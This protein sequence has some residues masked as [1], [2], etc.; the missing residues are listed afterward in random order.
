MSTQPVPSVPGV[1]RASWPRRAPRRLEAYSALCA[2]SFVCYIA[3]R[4]T[5]GTAGILFSAIGAGACGWA[6]LLTRALFDPA[7]R[8]VW[9]PRI[10]GTVVAVAG[11]ITVLAPAE[12]G[13]S[14]F[15]ANVYRLSGSAAMLL[16]FIEP[17]QARRGH[18]GVGEKRFRLTFLTVNAAQLVAVLGSGVASQV[19]ADV[20]RTDMIR[21]A[22]CIVG[23][24]GG[25]VA[26]WYRLRHPLAQPDG[27]GSARR[28]PTD[29]DRRLAERLLVLL[30]DEAIDSRPDLRIGDVA[31]HMGQPEYKVSQCISTVLGFPNFNRLINHHRIERAK[32]L[33]ADPDQGL[34][35][36]EVA[37]ECG[38]GSVGP[39]N[40]AFRE[41][42]GVTP[43]D[44]R[45]ASRRLH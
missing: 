39:F 24:V 13:L 3:G 1:S 17:F 4:L 20:W 31:A 11:A 18:A 15:A 43:R 33:L 10:V 29:E 22:C 2:V 32:R 36:L 44:F 26:V 16:A 45:A 21:I 19:P 8:D 42:V 38:F 34:P 25:A 37:F 30:R 12:G 5:D 14:G 23:L 40:R 41:Q 9:W 28:A 7:P 35:I 6:W 27:T